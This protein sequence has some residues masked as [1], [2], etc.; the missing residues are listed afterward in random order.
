M[1]S[2]MR[3]HRHRTDRLTPTPLGPT[4]RVAC[5]SCGIAGTFQ[6]RAVKVGEQT[7]ALCS[8]CAEQAAEGTERAVSVESPAPRVS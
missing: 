4:F 5:E 3:E 1:V 8:T 6:I 2:L 7:M